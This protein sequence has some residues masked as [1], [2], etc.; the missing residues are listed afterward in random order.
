MKRHLVVLVVACVGLVGTARAE[1]KPNPTGT[2]K[3]TGINGEHLALKLKLDGNKLTGTFMNDNV[4][5]E[6]E[7][8]TFKDGDVSF[9][10]P[11]PG[12]KSSE[13]T[14]KITGDT[15]K[16]KIIFYRDDKPESH[17]WEATRAKD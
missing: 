11:R 15:L 12:K 10:L 3:W 1:D 8:A 5:K 14:G 7:N 13:Y 9:T 16:G 6:I 2:W 17:D 4:K